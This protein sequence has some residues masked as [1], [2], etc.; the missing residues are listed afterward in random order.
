MGKYFWNITGEAQTIFAA[1]RSLSDTS[2]RRLFYSHNQVLVFSEE[3]ARKGI[4]DYIDVF[5]RDVEARTTEWMVVTPGKA[6]D[7]LSV[8]HPSAEGTGIKFKSVNQG[9]ECNFPC[10]RNQSSSI[11]RAHFKPYHRTHRHLGNYGRR[12]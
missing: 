11:C 4:Q 2:P 8:K 9:P 5:I 12:K 6:S 10:Q 7:F 3:L 1:T